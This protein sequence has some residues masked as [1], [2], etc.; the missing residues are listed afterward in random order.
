MRVTQ[1]MLTNNMLRNI[2]NSYQNLG[3]YMEQLSTG[4]KIN[5]P[6][7]DPVVAMKG[8]NYRTVVNQNEQYER[9]I[10]EVHNWLDNTD[11][12]LDKNQ[13]VLERLKELAVQA[14]NGTYEEGERGNI[15]AEV[16][17]LREQL[18]DVAN[19]KVNN[20]YIFSGTAT[21]GDNGN[22]PFQIDKDT[23]EVTFHGNNNQVKLE[24]SAGSQLPVNTKA[25]EFYNNEE[26]DLFADLL[27]F[28]KKLEDE[29]F[30]D[31]EFTEYIGVIDT[32]INNNVNARADLGARQNRIDLVESRVK[33]QTVT[34][35]DMMSKNEN[36]NLEEVIMNLTSQE[37]VH[38][39]ALSAGARV[40]Q[41]S[42]L[43]FLR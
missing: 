18:L 34:A 39:A 13:K 3:T 15:A 42:L 24:V 25:N 36:A 20:K 16:K 38:R 17:Q 33:E 10:G 23:L 11:S 40:I 2:S 22:P 12:A 28:T 9:N 35:K 21:T 7:D 27:E 4:K 26:N 1:S 14:A 8:M 43:D 6:S 30:S 29:S 41:P 31:N 37:A 19:T 32:H 5:R